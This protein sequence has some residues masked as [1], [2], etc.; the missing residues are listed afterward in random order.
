MII[1]GYL[2][3]SLIE[4]PGKIS[5]VVFVPGCNFRCP[6]C[7]NK[8]LVLHPEKLPS[9]PEKEVFSD[10]KK[11]KKWIDGVVI[12]G[13]EPTLQLDLPKFL[14]R[15]KDLG[16]LTMIETNGTK[17]EVLRK[18]LDMGLVDRLTMD[19][20]APLN[21]KNYNRASGVSC[22]APRAEP[23]APFC[24][25]PAAKGGTLPKQNTPLRSPSFAGYPPRIHPR[26]SPWLS[27]K[28]GKIEIIKE[29][30]KLILSSEI[31]SEFRTT[32]VPTLYTKDS[33]I[34]LAKQ[35]R[36]IS[37]QPS[38]INHS[39]FWFLQQFQPKN[40]LNP[41]FEKIEPYSGKF[42]EEILSAVK[43]YIP[44]AELRGV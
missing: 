9:T 40:C 34:E 5:S 12:T 30:I 27:A 21:S 36:Y 33:L 28:E 42:L 35:L 2:R 41:A 7:H 26:Q 14:Q 16:F 24:A 25:S 4:W 32:V 29:S 1:K 13:G 8:D 43:K 18:L 3:T 23:M 6:F 20:K 22:G 19:I 44:G 31:E 38:T 10:L 37:H 15:I 11:R 17:P 39:L